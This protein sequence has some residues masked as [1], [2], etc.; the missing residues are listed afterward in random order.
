MKIVICDDEKNQI[1]K[2]RQWILDEN[3]TKKIPIQLMTC[4]SGEELLF[5]IEDDMHEVDIIYLDVN[6]TGINGLEVAHKLRERGYLGEI[7]FLT[8]MYDKVFEAF[9][10]DAMHYILKERTSRKKFNEIFDRAVTRCVNRRQEIAVFTCAGETRSVP[11][12]SIRYFEVSRHLITIYYGG[13][14]TFEFYSTLGKIEEMLFA[15]GFIRIHKSILVAKRYIAKIAYLKAYLI[16]GEEL[17][18]G[19]SYYKALK[20]EVEATALKEGD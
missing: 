18:V 14:E 17:T 5:K 11:V 4:L 9:D 19:R 10:V 15:K 1:E 20:E 13:N 8:V 6:M 2:Y 16:T 7:I 3:Q 12:A